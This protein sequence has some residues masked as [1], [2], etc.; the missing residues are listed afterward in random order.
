VFYID[1]EQARDLVTHAVW[2]VRDVELVSGVVLRM[3]DVI[4]R[5]PGMGPPELT[6]LY[7]MLVAVSQMTGEP[8]EDQQH[9]L[10]LYRNKVGLSV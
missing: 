9:I 7:E 4:K 1:S 3:T 6:D 8:D 5:T 2:M 10:G